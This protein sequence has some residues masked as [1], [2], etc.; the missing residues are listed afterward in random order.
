LKLLN[1]YLFRS[2]KWKYINSNKDS[3]LR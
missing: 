1:K 3:C 2:R